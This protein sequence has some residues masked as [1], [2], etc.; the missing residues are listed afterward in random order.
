MTALTRVQAGGCPPV[1]LFPHAGGSPRFFQRWTRS[2]PGV[3][4]VGVTYPGRD[5]RMEERYADGPYGDDLV[6]FARAVADELVADGVATLGGGGPVLVGHSLGAFIAYETAA[7]LAAT[8]VAPA[9]LVV[10]GQ[11][12]PELRTAT[13]LHKDT[14]AALVADIVRQNPGSAQ[15]WEI[16]ELRQIFLPAV[17]EDYR[18][19]ETYVPGDGIVAEVLAC[20]GDQDEEVDPDTMAGWNRRAEL[21]HP[22]VV[23]SGGHFY[24]QPPDEQLPRLLA[25][26]FLDQS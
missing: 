19:L 9:R 2:L 23:L 13:A 6:G 21:A 8:G 4:L 20:Y 1:V 14:D 18:L 15:L 10:S 12:P 17:R 26:R 3:R 11:N 16:D 25:R 22:P 5:E 24:L 7:A